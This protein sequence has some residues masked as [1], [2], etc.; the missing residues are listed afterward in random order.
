MAKRAQT[1]EN[2]KGLLANVGNYKGKTLN[3]RGKQL[4]AKGRAAASARKIDISKTRYDKESKKVLGPMGKPVT[5]R[6][7][8]G[9]GNIA[10]YRNGVR[11]RASSSDSK[12]SGS[13]GKGSGSGPNGRNIKTDNSNNPKSNYK[14]ASRLGKPGEYQAGRGQ[15]SRLVRTPRP[16]TRGSQ[17]AYQAGAITAL[18]WD[19]KTKSWKKRTR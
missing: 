6:I 13:S 9:G 18:V 15:T 19:D 7:D 10:V 12:G 14:T 4:G 5:G 17:S 2:A 1:E 16:G 11:V 8:L 3:L